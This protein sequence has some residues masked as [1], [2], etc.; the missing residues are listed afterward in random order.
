M[1][2]RELAARNPISPQSNV[3][4]NCQTPGAC[5]SDI[6]RDDIS[7]ISQMFQSAMLAVF[8]RTTEV[9]ARTLVD[10]IRPDLEDAAHGRFLMD[11]KVFPYVLISALFCVVTNFSARNGSNVDSPNGQRIQERWINELFPLL[12]RISPG[13][14]SVLSK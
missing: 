10:A 9:G 2:V 7:W 12:E 8:A 4:I 13:C 11:C 14:T 5:K 6:F 1:T 3:V